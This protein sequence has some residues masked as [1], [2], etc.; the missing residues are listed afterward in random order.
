MSHLV[1]VMMWGLRSEEGIWG[2]FFNDEVLESNSSFIAICFWKIWTVAYEPYLP[3]LPFWVHGEV[4]QN[5]IKS[6]T[7]YY[8]IKLLS[9]FSVFFLQSLCN[10][11]I[12]MLHGAMAAS[13]CATSAF[14]LSSLLILKS[15]LEFRLIKKGI[16]IVF[17]VRLHSDY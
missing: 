10:I 17:V 8:A 5:A 14:K 1:V 3:P 6:T 9:P 16:F 12:K 4:R 11:P 2:P 15:A 7:I 13:H